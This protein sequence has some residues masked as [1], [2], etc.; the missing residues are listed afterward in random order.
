MIVIYSV[1]AGDPTERVQILFHIL[2]YINRAG[3][4]PEPGAVLLHVAAHLSSQL[5]LT[6][7]DVHLLPSAHPP[8]RGSAHGHTEQWARPDVSAWS[9]HEVALGFI[10]KRGFHLVHVSMMKMMKMLWLHMCQRSSEDAL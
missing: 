5:V 4:H 2:T 3:T 1:R 8:P 6:V 9:P 10:L 7:C